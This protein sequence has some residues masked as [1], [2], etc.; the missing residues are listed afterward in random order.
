MQVSIKHENFKNDYIPQ[1]LWSRHITDL[2][3]NECSYI[4]LERRRD[5]A[6]VLTVGDEESGY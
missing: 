6:Y 4:K 5:A 2:D 3:G 1:L